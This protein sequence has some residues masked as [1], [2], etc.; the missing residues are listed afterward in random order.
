[1]GLVYLAL[2]VMVSTSVGCA[3]GQ[4]PGRGQ[5]LHLIEP[6]TGAGYWLYVPEGYD[7]EAA[8]G[9]SLPLVMTFH[10]MKPFDNASYQIREWQQEADRYGYLVCAPELSTPDITS[11]VPLRGM[12]A[13]LKKDE[14]RILAVMDE[15]EHLC[16]IDPNAVLA[17]SWSYG[18][19]IAH[20][21]IN[22]HPRRF[23]CIAVKQSNFTEQILDPQQVVKYRDCKVGIF[24]TQNDF[25]ICREESKAAAKWYSRH[26]F[27]LTFAVFQDLGHERRPGIA[28]SFFA[29]TCN[30]TP[31]TPPVELARM[32]V[33]ELP[34]SET[35]AASAT[36]VVLAGPSATLDADHRDVVAARAPVLFDR[37]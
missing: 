16:S 34:A 30:A 20:Y 19:Y 33:L 3:V 28:S 5:K 35:A 6:T 8:A 14:R 22:Q 31:K 1:M 10:G 24:Y 25:K 36:Q 26:G 17:T 23:S 4:K 2:G 7:A 29:R 21:M 32:Q 11:P 13:S 15:L 27:D 12:T 9:H 18:G 37:P